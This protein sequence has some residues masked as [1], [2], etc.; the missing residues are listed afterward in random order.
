MQMTDFEGDTH[1]PPSDKTK[2]N[3]SSWFLSSKKQKQR[4]A[5]V[6]QYGPKDWSK[7]DKNRYSYYC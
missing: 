3:H 1:A 6:H 7:D 5:A 2:T 4:I